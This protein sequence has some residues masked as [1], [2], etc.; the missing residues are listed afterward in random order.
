MRL[1]SQS[2]RICTFLSGL[3][4]VSPSR[5]GEQVA[6]QTLQARK[7]NE[8][9]LPW[10]STHLRL[11]APST[12]LWVRPLIGELRSFELHGVA[13]TPLKNKHSG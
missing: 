6:Y 4:K 8:T 3:A 12:G 9:G 10:R 11:C 2:K 7:Q 13:K 1:V 5:L